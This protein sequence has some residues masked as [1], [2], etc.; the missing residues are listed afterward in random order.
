MTV[1]FAGI[2]R[3]IALWRLCCV[4]AS[5]ALILCGR[6]PCSAQISSRPLPYR[7]LYV[8]ENL[9]LDETVAQVEALMRRAAKVGYT[10]IVLH[11]YKFGVLD[12]Q[13]ADYF[14]NVEQ[15][16]TLAKALKLELIPCVFPFDEPTSLF[17]H[18][19]SLV[20]GMPVKDAPF[21]VQG[22]KADLTP[23]PD[24]NIKNGGFEEGQGD[25]ATG[26]DLQDAP[27]RVSFLDR[28]TRHSGAA[29]LRFENV[30]QADPRNRQ[31]RVGQHIA[32]KPFRYYRLSFWIKTRDLDRPGN[33]NVE[34]LPPG[35]H[36]HGLAYPRFGLPRT[37]DWQPEQILFN[38]QNHTE[39][40]VFL[41]VWDSKRGSLWL[42]DVK[43]EEIGLVNVVRREGCPLTVKGEDGTSYE[44]GRDFQPVRDEK[45]LAR[46]N[47]GDFDLYH[48]PP[49]LLLT[50][51]SRIREGQR[52]RV[53]FYH[54]AFIYDKGTACCLSHPKVYALLRDQM[55]RVEK[56]FHPSAIFMQHDEMRV[57]NWCTL[58]QAQH[59]T[60]GQLLA[61]N[62]RRCQQI[63]HEVSPQARLYVWSDMFDP[64]HN[65]HD[66][67]YLVNGTWAGSW[68]GLSPDV[69][70]VDW[71]FDVRKKDLPWFA[72]RGHKQILAGYYDDS[73]EYTVT[74]L[75]DSRNVKGIEGV[76]YTTW[77]NRYDDIE[78]YAQ[79]VWGGGTKTGRP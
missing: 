18:E 76:M 55:E 5:F 60:P 4:A 44:E 65:A 9:A 58:C 17:A 77:Q 25:K 61:E 62:I 20:E 45:M 12:R 73:A 43:L 16:K 36:E 29:A 54:P 35:T 10:G 47:S 32:L 6:A 40:T 1:I 46:P 41:G 30:G 49:S 11:D 21:L 69:G 51:N 8:A 26:W 70:I 24:A 7:W 52:L 68:E 56:L 33:I 15:I 75:K 59:K 34:I 22:G 3:D 19:P 53:S 57:A 39:A 23:D 14:R 79:T 42:D 28:A 38:S 48:T 72:A 64:Y 78:K 2:K 67:Y 31:G 37:Q 63:A 13:G 27:G 71:Y 66:D 50:P 74:W